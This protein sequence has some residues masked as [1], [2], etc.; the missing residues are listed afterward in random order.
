[1]AVEALPTPL[2]ALQED[3]IQAALD[4]IQDTQTPPTVRKELI[5][6]IWDRTGLVAAPPAEAKGS[7]PVEA[8]AAALQTLADVAGVKA[9][10]PITIQ[11]DAVEI[12][13]TEKKQRKRLGRKQQQQQ[14][15]P[16]AAGSAQQLIASV[17]ES[18]SEDA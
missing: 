9:A 17:C 4:M 15:D 8:F 11:G 3:A 10:E 13:T 14:E 7:V 2:H 6:E 16:P 1:M 5:T 18:D 12:P